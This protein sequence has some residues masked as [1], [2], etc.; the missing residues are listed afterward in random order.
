MVLPEMGGGGA[1]GKGLGLISP[2]ARQQAEPKL[3]QPPGRQG[4]CLS[5][6]LSEEEL[7]SGGA[8]AAGDL[9]IATSWYTKVKSLSKGCREVCRLGQTD[10]ASEPKVGTGEM[11]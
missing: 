1:A 8:G 9:G 4:E 2:S 5:F 6:L 7:S 11:A 3:C 10:P